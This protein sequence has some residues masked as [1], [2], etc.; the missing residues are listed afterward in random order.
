M[1]IEE[2]R[3]IEKSRA[4]EDGVRTVEE[5]VRTDFRAE[6][7]YGG[8]LA[9]DTLLSAQRPI[10]DHHDEPLFIIQHQT[11]ELWLKLSLHELRAVRAH[12]DADDVP[13]ARK[14]LARV[15]HVFRT[16]TEQWSVLATLTP[17]EYAEFRG[18]LGHSSGF[19]SFQYRAVEF[20]L[21]NKDERLLQVFRGRPVA[22]EL[23]AELLDSPTV[24]DAF[25]RHLAR[26]GHAVPQHVLDRDVRRAWVE[27]PALVP[28]H[29][30]I[31]E[32]TAAHWP[33]Y[34]TCED[35]VDLED[36]VQLWRFRHLRTVQRTIGF[37]TG[38][39][40]SSGVD[41]LKRALDLT[42]F[43]ELYTVRSGIGA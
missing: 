6:M 20:I 18:V 13:R 15:K 12:L 8:Y 29:R 9:L 7:D 30:A 21:G 2:N 5:G 25:L 23:L 35:L 26:A 19:Q 40:G 42:F 27:D 4:I 36:A 34:A 22:Q 28:V 1:A 43:P 17:S 10:S 37:A 41:F 38:T 16:L 39:G 3:A 33:Q 24:Y 31:Y 14:G 11:T 32:D